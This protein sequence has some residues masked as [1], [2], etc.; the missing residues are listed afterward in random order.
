MSDIEINFPNK[1]QQQIKIF[2]HIL[3]AFLEIAMFHVDETNSK[4]KVQNKPENN[5]TSLLKEAKGLQ[6]MMGKGMLHSS[7]NATD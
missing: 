1:A 3:L 4:L 2:I 5:C 6:L 7:V